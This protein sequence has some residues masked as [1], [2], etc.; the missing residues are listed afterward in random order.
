MFNGFCRFGNLGYFGNPGAFGWIMMI[1]QAVIWIAII[2]GIVFLIIWAIRR[3][4]RGVAYAVPG[5]MT[6]KEILQT[7]YARGEI[8]REQYQ[9]ML[10]DLS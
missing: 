5:Q 7:R 10:E 8:T 2:A 1:L 4:S 6:A 3:S 9:Q